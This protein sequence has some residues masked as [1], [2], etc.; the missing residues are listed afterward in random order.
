MEKRKERKERKNQIN[1]S[2][3][4]YEEKNAQKMEENKRLTILSIEEK[5]LELK[6]DMT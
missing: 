3:V 1:Q 4:E 6:K 2:E 5:R